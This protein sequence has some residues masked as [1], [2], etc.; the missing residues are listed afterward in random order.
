LNTNLLACAW[1]MEG[2][3]P[4]MLMGKPLLYASPLPAAIFG[5]KGSWATRT[6]PAAL[7]SSIRAL[8]TSGLC[9]KARSTA[10]RSVR[11]RTWAPAAQ[12]VR[13]MTIVS[14]RMISL[15]TTR[16]EELPLD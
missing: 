12:A 1:K 8:A 16:T 9:F 5:S 10:S 6:A 2:V 11:V 13:R 14:L 7:V 3:A 4:S 15:R